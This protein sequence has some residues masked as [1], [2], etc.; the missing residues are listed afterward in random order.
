MAKLAAISGDQL[1]D[2]PAM[3]ILMAGQTSRG[4]ERESKSRAA[5][6]GFA[7]MTSQAGDCLVRATQRILGLLMLSHEEAGRCEGL[8]RMALF[9]I[10]LGSALRELA[11]VEV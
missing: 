3:W 2:L 9:A 1:I 11:V 8:N 10:S 5:L 6:R 7:L 4:V